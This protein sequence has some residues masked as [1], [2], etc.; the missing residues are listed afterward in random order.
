MKK[1]LLLT[2]LYLIQTGTASASGLSVSPARLDF[3]LSGNTN[4]AKNI[5]VAN[6]TADVMIFEVY[7]DEFQDTIIV[8]P[9][10]FTLESGGRKEVS[11]SI[12]SEK[13]KQAQTIATSLSVV[14]TPLAQN[15][16]NIG[17]GAKIPLTASF[18]PQEKTPYRSYGFAVL[19]L[20]GIAL[21][22]FHRKFSKTKSTDSLK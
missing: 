22:L 17:A 18:S 1:I 15:K 13:L 12:D 4:V 8:N 16:V 20:I 3:E 5:V 21:L 9:E 2:S 10:S 6:P 11:V 7:A 19:G 14:G